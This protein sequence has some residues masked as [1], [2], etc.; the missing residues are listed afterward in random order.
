M[1]SLFLDNADH[2]L[3]V[4][5]HERS[6][7]LTIN[8]PAIPSQVHSSCYALTTSFYYEIAILPLQTKSPLF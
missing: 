4:R 2:L 8:P 7:T 3:A 6:Q 1:F 5:P